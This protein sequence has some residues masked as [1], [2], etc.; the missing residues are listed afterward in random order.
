MQI[1]D[2]LVQTGGLQ[3][4]AKELGIT[5]AQAVSGVQALAPAIL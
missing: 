5:E 3:S 1:L 2:M 4:I